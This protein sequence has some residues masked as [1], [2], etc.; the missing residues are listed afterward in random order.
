MSSLKR[1]WNLLAIVL[2]VSVFLAAFGIALAATV[3]VSQTVPSSLT[4][5]EVDILD[6]AN[7]ILS[8][9]RQVTELVLY[10]PSR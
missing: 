3:Q 2:G 5:N 10:S 9:D 1:K 4:V 8:H 7:L 6:D